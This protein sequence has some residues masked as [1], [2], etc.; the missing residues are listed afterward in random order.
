MASPLGKCTIRARSWQW[1]M[2]LSIRSGTRLRPLGARSAT[3]YNQKL[4]VA[5]AM[6]K[7]DIPKT[8]FSLGNL[9]WKHHGIPVWPRFLSFWQD[10]AASASAPSRSSHSAVRSGL[11]TPSVN[12]SSNPWEVQLLLVSGMFGNWFGIHSIILVAC[13]LGCACTEKTWDKGEPRTGDLGAT[14]VIN[15]SFWRACSTAVAL[16]GAA[17]RLGLGWP[18]MI[19]HQRCSFPWALSQR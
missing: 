18:S 10:T 9:N 5:I 16:S 4:A 1:K 3:F 8:Q 2:V 14:N 17:K 19:P 7:E 15:V 12:G 6:L 13:A 11:L